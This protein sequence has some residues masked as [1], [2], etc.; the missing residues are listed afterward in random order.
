MWVCVC[1]AQ[2]KREKS[3]IVQTW[4]EVEQRGQRSATI[5]ISEIESIW[6]LWHK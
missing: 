6:N 4:H 2:K 1:H 3:G 5:S